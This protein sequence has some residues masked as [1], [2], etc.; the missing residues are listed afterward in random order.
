MGQDS[1]FVKELVLAGPAIAHVGRHT[2]GE[3]DGRERW[4]V[5]RAA[6]ARPAVVSFL[7]A[8]GW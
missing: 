4:L 1:A 2:L 6:E 5:A 8:E 7:P 3:S